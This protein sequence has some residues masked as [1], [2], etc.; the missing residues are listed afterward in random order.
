MVSEYRNSQDLSRYWLVLIGF[1][2]VWIVKFIEKPGV[3][4]CIIGQKSAC[5][6][7]N[8]PRESPLQFKLS[9]VVVV[10][11][12]NL[13]DSELEFLKSVDQDYCRS[14]AV[15]KLWQK[16]LDFPLKIYRWALAQYFIYDRDCLVFNLHA[17]S[18]FLINNTAV[19]RLAN[20]ARVNW[21]CAGCDI[22]IERLVPFSSFSWLLWLFVSRCALVSQVQ[23]QNKVFRKFIR[24]LLNWQ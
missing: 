24:W 2:I 12:S 21:I 3:G 7:C 13:V 11:V 9:L 18:K 15:K 16:L 22:H 14:F 23:Q 6:D 10:R 19:K 1:Y 4:I 20:N 17:M 8:V 5:R